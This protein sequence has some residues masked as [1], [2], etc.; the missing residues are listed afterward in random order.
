M[1]KKLALVSGIPRMVDEAAAPAI[2]D[3]NI[4]VISDSDVES[5]HYRKASNMQSGDN[6][7]LPDSGTYE[8]EELEIRLNGQRLRYLQD[9][10]YVGSGTKTQV[11]FNFD[12]VVGDRIDFRVDRAP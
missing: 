4:W 10:I 12:M 8:G 5:D 3:S 1:S 2:Y 11:S 6:V 9:Y 7:T